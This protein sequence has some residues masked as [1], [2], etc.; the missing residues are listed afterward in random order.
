[1]TPNEKAFLDMIAHSEIG[2]A[3]LAVSDNGYNVIVGSTPQNPHLFV[4]YSD[5]P[6]VKVNL[7][8]GLWSTAAGRYQ[9]LGWVFDAY[10]KLLTLPDF[11]P[12]SQDQIA[13]QQIKERGAL[14]D[15]KDG[16]F[17]TAIRKVEHVWASLPGAG[18]A[19]HENQLTALRDAY[20]A[21]GGTLNA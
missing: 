15:I 16:H 20:L 8:N 12:D 21:A 11:G 18:Y 9:T 14:Q 1:M 13:L 5:H 19:Q 4:S 2:P 6:H 10:K 17:E 7:G 3:L